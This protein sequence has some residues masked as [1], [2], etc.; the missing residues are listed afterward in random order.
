MAR[1]CRDLIRSEPG[2]WH[3]IGSGHRFCT[4]RMKEKTEDTIHGDDS[5]SQLV[6]SE[7]SAHRHVFRCPE[8]ICDPVHQLLI[9]ASLFPC[10]PALRP[11]RGAEGPC[12]SVSLRTQARFQRDPQSSPDSTGA[13]SL[14]SVFSL[15]CA[16]FCFLNMGFNSV[17]CLGPS[18]PQGNFHSRVCLSASVGRGYGRA[19]SPT[20]FR[21]VTLCKG[22]EKTCFG[23]SG[24]LRI[25]SLRPHVSLLIDLKY[26]CHSLH[27]S[28]A[29]LSGFFWSP[30][31][32]ADIQCA[33]RWKHG[34]F[35]NAADRGGGRTA[36]WP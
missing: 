13:S 35:N 23:E 1:H 25:C 3:L 22:D 21:P 2:A 18:F 15:C 10:G 20:S 34:V 31:G 33:P 4:R 5:I 19:Q 11:R 24:L 16:V 8:H 6:T 9:G 12:P 17:E 26:V 14:I 32:P 27:V 36:G 28:S 7:S 29:S 30:A